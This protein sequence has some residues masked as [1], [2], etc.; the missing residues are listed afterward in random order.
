[1]KF[2]KIIFAFIFFH[3]SVSYAEPEGESEAVKIVAQ[4]YR[5]FAW[6]A[7]IDDPVWRGHALLDQSLPVL[8]RY[9]D[10]T[11]ATLIVQDRKCASRSHEICKLDFSPIWDSQDPGASQMKIVIGSASDIV[12]VVFRYPGAAQKIELSYKMTKTNSG[13][14][15]ADIRYKSGLTLISILSAKP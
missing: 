7:V 8:E 6:E 1:M 9:F 15:V 12:N 3:A 5:D 4:L 2:Q 10:H 11:L 13:W 14:R